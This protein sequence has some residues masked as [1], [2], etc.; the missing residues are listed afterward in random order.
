MHIMMISEFM[1]LYGVFFVEL[2]FSFS[3]VLLSGTVGVGGLSCADGCHLWKREAGR[4]MI[5]RID[6]DNN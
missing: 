5:G 3:F 2:C 4:I 1:I 6:N